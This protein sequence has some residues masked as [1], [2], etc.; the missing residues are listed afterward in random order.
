ALDK[1]LWNCLWALRSAGTPTVPAVKW[2]RVY[3]ARR[4]LR[5][6]NSSLNEV[7]PKQGTHKSG[8]VTERAG[9]EWLCRSQLLLK[10]FGRRAKPGGRYFESRLQPRTNLTDSCTSCF[11]CLDR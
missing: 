3:C 11:L 9:N 7:L 8:S 10:R 1:E 6:V 4:I 5:G 2:S